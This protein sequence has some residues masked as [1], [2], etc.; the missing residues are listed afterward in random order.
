MDKQTR[1]SQLAKAVMERGVIDLDD[2]VREFGIS[3][4]T[5]RRDLN[6]LADQQLVVRT[7]GGA[8]AH[9]RSGDVPLRFRTS[10]NP[11]QKHAIALEAATMVTPGMVVGLTGGT[12]TTAIAHEIAIRAAADEAYLETPV[13]VVTNAVNIANDLT[14]RPQVRVVMTGGAARTSSFELVGPLAMLIL[15]SIRMDLYFLGV[16]AVDFDSGGFY[17]HVEDEAAINAAMVQ[18]AARTIVPADS[19]KLGGAA[20]ARICGFDDVDGIIVDAGAG[21]DQL[22]QLRALVPVTVASR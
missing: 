12:T 5:A 10:R 19:S 22:A 13:T 15:P 20:F 17:T 4:A 11:G 8:R 2:V 7:R 14:I 1:L 18:A 3:P 6:S 9:A 16:N 21:A